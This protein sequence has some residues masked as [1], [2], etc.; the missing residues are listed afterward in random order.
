MS[1]PSTITSAGLSISNTTIN[2]TT[3]YTIWFVL[4]NALQDTSFIT[5]TFPSSVNL[6]SSTCSSPSDPSAAC[7]IDSSI[8][9]VQLTVSVAAGEN[10]TLEVESVRNPPTTTTT[11]T[12][13][14]STYY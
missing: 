11:E 6:S 9:T 8:I 13:Q 1:D 7:S 12:I 4:V 3:Q 5:Y 14:I 2:I 10:F